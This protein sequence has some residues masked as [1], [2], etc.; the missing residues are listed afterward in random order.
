LKR[1][2]QPVSK[3]LPA[4]E[5]WAPQDGEEFC[6]PYYSTD[7]ADDVNLLGDNL[8]TI[9][10]I[11]ESLVAVSNDVGLEENAEKAKYI[12]MSRY[13]NA[14]QNH[15]VKHFTDLLKI[16]LISYILEWQ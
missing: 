5:N 7:Y 4:R 3:S 6:D 14:G 1:S 2:P 9:K 10:K 15:N 11:T 8:N 12:S 13:Q 16:R